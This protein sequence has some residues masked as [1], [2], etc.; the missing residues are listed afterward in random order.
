LQQSRLLFGLRQR[1]LLCHRPRVLVRVRIHGVAAG[2]VGRACT[3]RAVGPHHRGDEV[4]G[5]EP[6]D[7]RAPDRRR[8]TVATSAEYDLTAR[9]EPMNAPA[10]AP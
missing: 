6:V 2:Q 5:R 1:H 3:A 8:R 10:P 7:K 9:S 4:R